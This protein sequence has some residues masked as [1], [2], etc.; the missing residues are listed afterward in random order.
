MEFL[1]TIR[2]DWTAL[3]DLPDLA[4]LVEE[5]RRTGRELIA[6]GVIVRIWRV[7]GQRANIGVW[8]ARD[9]TELVAHLDRLPLR[10]WLDAEV[11]ALAAHELEAP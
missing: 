5:E 8:R 11:R 2:Q 4:A 10:R 1:V 3:R 6:E 9:A 7:P